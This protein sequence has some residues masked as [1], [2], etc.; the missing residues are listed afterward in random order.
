MLLASLLFSVDLWA[1]GCVIYQMLVGQPPFKAESEYLIF[2]KI[3]KLEFSFP[4]DFPSEAKDL[5]SHLLV[6]CIDDFG[7][8]LR[9][10]LCDW[11]TGCAP[12]GWWEECE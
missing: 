8:L 2:Q 4:P 7:N 10:V 3:L 5:V 1:L 12:A 9:G 6:S 11:L